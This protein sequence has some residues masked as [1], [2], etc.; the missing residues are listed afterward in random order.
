M[1]AADTAFV[2][3]N[4]LVYSVDPCDP[5]KFAAAES[6]MNALWVSGAG[7]ISWQVLHEFYAAATRKTGIPAKAARATVEQIMSWGPVDSSAALLERAWT[8]MDASQISYWDSL[9]VAA[10][11]IAGCRW[12][13]SE[14]LQH[15]QR[16]GDVTVVSPFRTSPEE[17]GIARAE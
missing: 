15:G 2:D 7:R 14:D 6:W 11:E 3:T 12:L 13:L 10:A 5:E 4:L 17:L 1:S 9:I 16:F 8:W